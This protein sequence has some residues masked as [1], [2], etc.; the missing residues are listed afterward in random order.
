M[1]RK[2]ILWAV[3]MLTSTGLLLTPATA[4]GKGTGAAPLRL[5]QS[6]LFIEI[7]ATDGDAGL[8]LNLDGESG[9][10]SGSSTRGAR[11]F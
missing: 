6:N 9:T 8:Q 11:R 5:A 7:N 1:T 2:A 10:T 4:G 3:A